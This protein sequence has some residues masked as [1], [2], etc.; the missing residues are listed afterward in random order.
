MDGEF[1]LDLEAHG[2]RRE[3]LDV[4]P[5]KHPVA[6]EH[7]GQAI[8]EGPGDDGGQQPVAEPVSGPVGL[9]DIGGARAV[10]H[11]EVVFAQPL[12][13]GRRGSGVVGGVPVHQQ[14]DFGIDV[15]EH[16]PHHVALALQRLGTDHGAG[17]LRLLGGAVGGVV[18]VHVDG[19]VGQHPAEIGDH[20]TDGHLL[21][22]AGDK[23]GDGGCFGH[24][25]VAR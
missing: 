6:G 5:G 22:V 3:V 14:V 8:A 10:D 17:G 16:P 2:Q 15:G 7:V 19:R 20:G 25:R 24:G 9:L 21:V 4:A 1:G 23:N 12:D 13:H 18:V 11:V